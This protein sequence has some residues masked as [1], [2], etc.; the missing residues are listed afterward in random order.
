MTPQEIAAN[1]LVDWSNEL[2]KKMLDKLDKPNDKGYPLAYRSLLRQEIG[3][4]GEVEQIGSTAIRYQLLLP[5]YYVY[6]DLGVKGIKSTYPSSAQSPY[7]YK[8]K[9]PGS[10]MVASLEKFVTTVGVK[11]RRD[12]SQLKER[13]FDSRKSIAFA[14]GVNVKKKGIAAR[15]FISDVV[16]DA[17]IQSLSDRLA[18]AIG[19]NFELTVS[20]F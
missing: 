14:I 18:E 20:D 15:R 8:F 2:Q 16:T 3:A 7:K 19:D 6:V 11:V 5:D 1:V 12:K 9:F 4:G 10:N 13:V 17:E